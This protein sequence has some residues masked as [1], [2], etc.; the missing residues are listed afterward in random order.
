MKLRIRNLTFWRFSVTISMLFQS[1]FAW[2]KSNY[3]LPFSLQCNIIFLSLS[4]SHSYF[5]WN[6]S[7]F[8]CR[9]FTIHVWKVTNEIQRMFALKLETIFSLIR[10]KRG[11][12]VIRLKVTS[13]IIPTIMF[14]TYGTISSDVSMSFFK[15]NA[16]WFRNLWY[17]VKYYHHD[18]S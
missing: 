17:K 9:Y 4:L 15:C 6:R 1:I 2:Q 10:F 11:G 13:H 8:N 14:L 3:N 5:P 7:E 16:N 12:Y 18:N